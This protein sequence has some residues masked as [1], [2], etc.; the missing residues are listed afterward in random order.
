MR[1]GG[2]LPL[3]D[4]RDC[5]LAYA[6]ILAMGLAGY[7]GTPWWLVLLGA[8]CLTLDGWWM[9]LRLLHQ[10]PRVPWSSKIMT[11]F[12]TGILG[13]IG[14]AALSFGVGRIARAAVGW[15]GRSPLV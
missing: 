14:F 13:N 1:R 15:L 5:M 11:Y 9:K 3:C 12:V 4:N 10:H 6:I 7:A 2:S 8:A